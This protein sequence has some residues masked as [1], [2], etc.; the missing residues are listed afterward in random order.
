VGALAKDFVLGFLV[1]ILGK[2][3]STKIHKL[4][5]HIVEAIKRHGAVMNGD[6]SCNEALH[7][8]DKRRYCR[9]SGDGDTFRPQLLR[10]GQGVLEI[11]ARL[12][13]EAEE[14]EG[15]FGDEGAEDVVGVGAPVGGSRVPGGSGTVPPL[16][17]TSGGAT[18]ASPVIPRSADA[19]P[20]DALSERR[21]LAAVAEALGEPMGGTAVHVT[22]SFKF[23]P[24]LPCCGE[25]SGHPLQHLRATP[26]YRGLPWNDGLAYRLPGDAR[27]VVR[28]GEARAIV[29]AVG[30][31][32]RQ[33]IV[34]AEMSICESEP[35]CPLV[36]AGCTRL[37]WSMA[38]GAEW[39]SL[40][41]IPFASVLR[42]EH[43]VQDFDQVTRSHGI[44]ATPRTIRDSAAHRRAARFFVNVFYPWP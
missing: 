10:V 13:S 22:N 20:L 27:A 26:L 38:P 23:S 6:T 18:N 44:T 19:V 39:P 40:R 24:R 7:V 29:H 8:H 14:F 41:C 28:Y 32:A 25:A 4:L 36:A 35:G 33:V 11:Q 2:W 16:A 1:P 30:G 37:H 9:T 17:V 15:W 3:Y 31:E 5:A 12:A 21:G 42:L 43:I 34:V